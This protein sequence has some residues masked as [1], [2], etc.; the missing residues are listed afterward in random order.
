MNRDVVKF[1][2][3]DWGKAWENSVERLA[4]LLRIRKVRGLNH[5]LDNGYP[6]WQPIKT[7]NSRDLPNTKQECQTMDHDVRFRNVSLLYIR[8]VPTFLGVTVHGT[9]C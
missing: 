4:I 8:P 6:D 1:A 3:N 7:Q 9:K 5:G 2:G